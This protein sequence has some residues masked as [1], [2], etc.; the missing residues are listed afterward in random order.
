[1]KEKYMDILMT[2]FLT[3]ISKND[4]QICHMLAQ[5][6]EEGDIGIM[7]TRIVTVLEQ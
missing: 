2:L 3:T 4:I 5:E 1:M 6:L 7:K